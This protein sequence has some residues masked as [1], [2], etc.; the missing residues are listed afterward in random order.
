[1]CFK[2][3]AKIQKKIHPNKAFHK[4]KQNFHISPLP[5]IPRRHITYNYKPINQTC[6]N[7][8]GSEWSFVVQRQRSDSRQMVFQPQ[9]V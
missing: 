2:S 8:S 1:M 9:A 7:L 6:P 5:R 4:K 3:A